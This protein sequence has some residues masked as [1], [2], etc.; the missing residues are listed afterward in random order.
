LSLSLERLSALCRRDPQRIGLSATQRP[1]EEVARYL[2]GDREVAILDAGEPPHLEIAVVAPSADMKRPAIPEGEAGLTPQERASLM[3]SVFRQVYEL[4]TQHRSTIVFV[5]SR[6]QAERI[7]HQ[8]NE[9]AGEELARAHHGS[10]ARGERLEAED[11]LSRGLLRCICATSSLE[12]GIDMSAVDLVIQVESP[13]SVARGLQRVGRAGHAV[14]AV[15]RG[16]VLPVFRGD[17]LESAAVVRGMLDGDVEPIATPRQP[18]DVL[19]QQIV[20]MAAVEPW[21]V[22]ALA[23]L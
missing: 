17:L 21:A 16:R 19:A 8:L 18:L 22:D 9:M 23:A 10:V 5:N 1:L 15:S 3:P 4:V 14:G 6:R 7:A 2:G 11:L 12:L 20:A 13:G